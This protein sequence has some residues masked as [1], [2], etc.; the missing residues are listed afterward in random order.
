M[1]KTPVTKATLN[2]RLHVLEALCH[3]GAPLNISNQLGYDKFMYTQYGRSK[4]ERVS[5][6]KYHVGQELMLTSKAEME[7]QPCNWLKT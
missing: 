5:P 6:L 3:R 7:D 4:T 2:G 1:G